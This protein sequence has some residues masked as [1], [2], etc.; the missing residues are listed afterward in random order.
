MSPVAMAQDIIV[1][2]VPLCGKCHEL[3]ASDTENSYMNLEHDDI[4]E[5]HV[6]ANE[7][8]SV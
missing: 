1:L 2:Y 4:G 8:V 7:N 6:A 5:T 3:L